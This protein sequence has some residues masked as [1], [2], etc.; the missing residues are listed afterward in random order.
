MIYCLIVC[1]L[2]SFIPALFNGPSAWWAFAI[3]VHFQK[4]ILCLITFYLIPYNKL[5]IKLI[6]ALV[7]AWTFHQTLMAIIAIY[8]L[9]NT[10]IAGYSLS[11]IFL[12]MSAIYVLYRHFD[13]PSDIIN[14]TD[15]FVVYKRPLKRNKPIRDALDLVL[16]SFGKE[17][18]GKFIICRGYAYKYTH[19]I[20]KKR[21]INSQLDSVK[22]LTVRLRS[23]NNND[24]KY[25]DS[26][27]NTKWS[28]QHN[29]YK[30]FKPVESY[31]NKSS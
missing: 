15:I 26:I 1:F 22:Y 6:F 18:G 20:I 16:S 25:L 24:V 27:I 4:L 13:R 28:L 21:K 14:Q 29:C 7:C 11:I 10:S 5:K 2:L 17:G 3:S 19:E 31:V 9:K 8:E 23:A 12:L 30:I